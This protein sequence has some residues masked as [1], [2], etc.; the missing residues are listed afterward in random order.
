MPSRSCRV[1][2]FLLWLAIPW[3]A[4]AAPGHLVIVGGG[5]IPPEV[6]AK[7]V[8]L[9]GGSDPAVAVFPQASEVPETGERAVA[10]WKH[11]G[12]AHAV[13]VSL[14]DPAA[15]VRTVNESSI[16]WFPGGDQNR[17]MSAFEGTGVAEAIVARYR[18][19]AVVGGTSA[20]AAV[21]SG[22]MITGDADLE[23]V[24]VGATRTAAGIGL[25]PEAI[26]DQHFMKRQRQN[27]LLSL[28][29]EHPDLIGVGIDEQT[30]VVVSGSRFDVLGRS[31]V[32][33]LDARKAAVER[34][35]PGQLS[36]GRDIRVHVLTHGMSFDLGR[37]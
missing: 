15:A 30:A 25:W 17:L 11:A 5:N 36:A 34:R 16:I 2:V 35:A 24:T 1:P 6:F 9:A 8:A 14:A 3:L 20:G 4:A 13:V 26:V 31:S 23:S 29:L 10:A 33:V 7:A 19:G 37:R 21:I 32:L 12:A 18:Q 27:R 22:V 28:V